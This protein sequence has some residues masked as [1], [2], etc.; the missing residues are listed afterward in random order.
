MLA[1]TGLTVTVAT[2]TAFTATMAVPLFPSLVAVIVADPTATP[3]T[4]PLADSV[5]T[6]AALVVQVT[7]RPPR[8]LPAESLVVAVSCTVP[9]ITRLGA[10]GLTVTVATGASVTETAAVPLFPSLVA[11]IVADPAPTP[12]TKPLADTVATPAA[13]VVHVSARPVSTFPAESFGVAVSW[14]VPPTRMPADAGLTVTVATGTALTV[15]AAVP[16]LPSLV[17]VI[18]ADPTATPLTNPPAD[19]VATPAALVVQVTTRPLRTLP[20]E[21]LVVAVSCTAPPT[22]RL[23]AAGLT[24]TVATGTS[25]TEMAAV[26]LFPSLVAVIAADPAPTPLTT[27]LADTVATPAALVAHVTA[28]PVRT[29]PA[30]SLGVAVS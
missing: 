7:T 29:L 16:L 12:V 22:T 19:T 5:A 8:T 14:V 13:L 6:P 2:G 28:R 17:A 18:V 15:T 25:V 1:D 11:V 3:L 10:A 4:N 20:A 23:G 30:E 24:V 21:S 27:P 9:P 26:P